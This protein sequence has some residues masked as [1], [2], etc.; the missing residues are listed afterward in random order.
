MRKHSK[1][2]TKKWRSRKQKQ[3]KALESLNFFNKI[4]ELKQVGGKFPNNQL[5]YLII[6]RLKWIMEL[7]NSM[8]I[9]DSSTNNYSPT[10]RII[11]LVII[12]SSIFKR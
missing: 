5:T 6:D 8:K 7:H 4:N 3:V 12:A 1:K 10:N 2:K 9:N 11:I